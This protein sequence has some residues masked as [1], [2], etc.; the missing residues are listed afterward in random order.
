MIYIMM[1]EITVL[2]MTMILMLTMNTIAPMIIIPVSRWS[3]MYPF[4]C[5]DSGL[6]ESRATRVTM[7]A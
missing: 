4:E 7:N 5:G 2:C 6:V 3:L 1:I